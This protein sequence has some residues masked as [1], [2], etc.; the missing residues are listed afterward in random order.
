MSNEYNYRVVLD[1]PWNPHWQTYCS[2]NIGVQ[3]EDWGCARSHIRDD[4]TKTYIF[5]FLDSYD[6]L[7]FG[8]KYGGTGE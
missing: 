7:K 4:G 6:A 3:R 5:R 8:L 1:G 2:Q